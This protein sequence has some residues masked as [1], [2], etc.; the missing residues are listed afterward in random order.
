MRRGDTKTL[1]ILDIDWEID[2]DEELTPVHE[3]KYR[4]SRPGLTP[5]VV[6]LIEPGRKQPGPRA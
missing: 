4:V 2:D 6:A 1:F 5:R 3:G